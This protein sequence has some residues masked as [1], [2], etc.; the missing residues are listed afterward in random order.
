MTHTCGGCFQTFT[1]RHPRRY[2]SPACRLTAERRER[3]HRVAE[4]KWIAGTDT[5]DNIAHRLG[6]ASTKTLARFLWR[7]DERDWARKVERV[8]LPQP[9]Q[10][11][12]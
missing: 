4:F 10:W 8:D 6:F 7:A 1:D 5:W 11:A 9:R 3:A 2:C 12:A